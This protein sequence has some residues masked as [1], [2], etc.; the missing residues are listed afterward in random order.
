MKEAKVGDI[1]FTAGFSYLIIR[2]RRPV[3]ELLGPLGSRSPYIQHISSGAFD[4]ELIKPTEVYDRDNLS[5]E[6]SYSIRLVKRPFTKKQT[7]Q[8]LRALSERP[9]IKIVW[10]EVC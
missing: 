10:N 2:T 1:L 9:E 6:A 5:D 8:I 4:F 7:D 3:I